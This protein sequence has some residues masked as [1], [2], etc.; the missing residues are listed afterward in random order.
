MDDPSRIGGGLQGP[1]RL[2]VRCTG[3]PVATVPDVLGVLVTP[4]QVVHHVTHCRTTPDVGVSHQP[5][6]PATA[7]D[8][9]EGYIDLGKKRTR[10]NT[11][12]GAGCPCRTPTVTSS[13]PRRHPH[14]HRTAWQPALV[15][16]VRPGFRDVFRTHHPVLASVPRAHKL[17]SDVRIGDRLS[18]LVSGHPVDAGEQFHTVEADSKPSLSRPTR[19]IRATVSE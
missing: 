4:P 12:F 5:D 15:A 13:H 17:R 10:R 6:R 2:D 8:W 9:N 3:V 7:G 14:R 19:S 1:V 11:E 16:K 18:V